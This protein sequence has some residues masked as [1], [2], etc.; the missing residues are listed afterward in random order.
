MR[1]AV[2]TGRKPPPVLEPAEH[3]LVL[4]ATFVSALVVLDGCLPARDA[5][6]YLLVLQGFTEPIGIIA[7]I[8]EQP[9]HVGQP[10]DQGTRADVVADGSGNQE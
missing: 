8:S 4:V 2:I 6:T 3:D 1:A 9:L 5:K 10:A 7:T